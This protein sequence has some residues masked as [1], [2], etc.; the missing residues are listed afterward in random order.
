MHTQVKTKKTQLSVFTGY[1]EYS[2]K[3]AD[4]GIVHNGNAVH[5]EGPT[6]PFVPDPAYKAEV[7]LDHRDKAFALAELIR[8]SAEYAME[9]GIYDPAHQI[10][11]IQ[12]HLDDLV[13]PRGNAATV[14]GFTL[15][16]DPYSID[17]RIV[18]H[19]FVHLMDNASPI[20]S[21]SY[22]FNA[23][24]LT[25]MRADLF[26][27]LLTSRGK[28]GTER[29]EEILMF[30][31]GM[32]VDV[33]NVIGAVTGKYHGSGIS[34]F[35]HGTEDRTLFKYISGGIMAVA[36]LAKNRF[37]LDRTMTDLFTAQSAYEIMDGLLRT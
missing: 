28:S 23:E 3:L 24:V 8:Q 17:D 31:A 12:A 30:Y 21:A 20:Y 11:R 10:K 9:I 32:G 18:S 34:D 14:C 5:L 36:T 22:A 13:A 16:I 2:A 26:S 19:E 35:A 29:T 33:L 6:E 7:L 27:A 15:K 25:E 4:F 37:D 1:A